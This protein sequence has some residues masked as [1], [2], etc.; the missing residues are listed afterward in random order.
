MEFKRRILADH[1]KKEK[2]TCVAEDS[3][4]EGEVYFIDSG[5]ELGKTYYYRISIEN[6][7][8]EVCTRTWYQERRC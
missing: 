6:F 8:D 2:M 7:D 5:L 4:M 1:R 3:A